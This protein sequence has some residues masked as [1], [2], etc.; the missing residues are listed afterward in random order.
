MGKI[1]DGIHHGGHAG[2][3]AIQVHAVV[4]EGDIWSAKGTFLWA[5]DEAVGIQALENCTVTEG[6]WEPLENAV[7]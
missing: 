4:E 2:G 5:D 1:S 6:K 3:D 7:H